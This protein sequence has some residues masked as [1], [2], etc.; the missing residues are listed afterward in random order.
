M[1][2]VTE[3]D[4]GGLTT[5]D[6]IQ[7]STIQT[8][9]NAQKY[10]GQ[11]QILA[12]A[13]LKNQMGDRWDQS[14]PTVHA[15]VEQILASELGPWDFSTLIGQDNYLIIYGEDDVNAAETTSRQIGKRV[16]AGLGGKITS[17]LMD[18]RPKGGKLEQQV[19]EDTALEQPGTEQASTPLHNTKRRF[20]EKTTAWTEIPKTTQGRSNSD[21]MK[22]LDETV[23]AADSKWSEKYKTGYVP[24]WNAKREVLAGYAIIPYKGNGK[25]HFVSGYDLIGPQGSPA[26]FLKIDAHMLQSQIE[27]CGELYRNAFTSLLATQLH[28]Q[29]LST[30]TGRK[31]IQRIARD[32]PESL[33]QF[34]MVQIVG[35]PE[36]TPPT[37][38]AQRLVGLPA[39]F[40]ALTI[41]IPSANYS[42]SA[43]AGMGAT[44]V[45]YEVNPRQSAASLRTDAKK[46]IRAA[47]ASKLLTTFEHVPNIAVATT[48]KEAGAIFM[49]GD[50]LGGYLDAPEN[51]RRLSLKDLK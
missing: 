41:R 27:V 4:V 18:V 37:S 23:Q 33:K 24:F 1:I 42:I 21:K 13:D 3:V 43:C 38:L 15:T 31:E 9:A 32:I 29:T 28:F 35:I 50:V 34:L 46:I 45:A 30:A 7:T 25:S 10:P 19:L 36:H 14:K 49:S 26:N 39:L 20:S 6:E 51:I 16:K 47:K 11:M 48:L 40:R 12:F 5:S 44:T 2:K 22:V 17:Q 8:A